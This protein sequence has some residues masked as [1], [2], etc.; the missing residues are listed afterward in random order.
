MPPKEEGEEDERTVHTLHRSSIK[1]ARRYIYIIPYNELYVLRP[2]HKSQ[3]D[4]L[5]RRLTQYN[6]IAGKAYLLLRGVNII[7]LQFCLIN[8]QLDHLAN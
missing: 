6:T 4:Q 3:Q 8:L 1:L 5:G 2:F 7:F